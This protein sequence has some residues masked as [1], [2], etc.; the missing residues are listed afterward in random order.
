[1]DQI[2]WDVILAIF[3]SHYVF[4]VHD[5]ALIKFFL[6]KNKA[7]NL[8]KKYIYLGL[9]YDFGPSKNKGFRHLKRDITF[10]KVNKNPAN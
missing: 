4:Q 10:S 5:F 3:S 2:N 1:M 8:F 9:G 6:T 7:S